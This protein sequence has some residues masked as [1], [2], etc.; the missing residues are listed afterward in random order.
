M[1]HPRYRSFLFLP[2]RLDDEMPGGRG[3]VGS[4]PIT[5]S[6]HQILLLSRD[7]SGSGLSHQ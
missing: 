2:D 3:V 7:I 6:D 4:D 5:G 1:R